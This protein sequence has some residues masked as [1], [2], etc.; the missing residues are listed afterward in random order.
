VF[1]AMWADDKFDEL[2]RQQ[3]SGQ[4]LWIY[5]LVGPHTTNVPG[6]SRAFEGAFL[7]HLRWSARSFR[8]CWREI[9]RRRM[10]SADW[11]RGVLWLPRGLMYDAPA[12]PNVVRGWR[13]TLT[14]IPQCPLKAVALTA[15]GAHCAERGPDFAAAFAK[16]TSPLRMRQTVSATVPATVPATVG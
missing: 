7:D 15:L 14:T 13:D 12:N 1:L 4:T 16:A 9:E 8:K 2:T 3:P 11:N 5:L 10:A 6:L